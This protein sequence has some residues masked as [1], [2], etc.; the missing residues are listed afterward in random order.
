MKARRRAELPTSITKPESRRGF[1]AIK[2]SA[3]DGR[4]QMITRPTRA[5]SF[6]AQAS[7]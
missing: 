3:S 6:D 1:L 7:R 5:K 4:L 2:T